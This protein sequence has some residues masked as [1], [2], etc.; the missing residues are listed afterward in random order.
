MRRSI[1]P[2]GPSREI[3]DRLSLFVQPVVQLADLLLRLYLRLVGARRHHHVSLTG[4]ARR[5]IGDVLPTAWISPLSIPNEEGA[6]EAL[7]AATSF[8]TDSIFLEA[9]ERP[10]V[11]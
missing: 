10:R 8:F 6:A 11:R 1:S 9:D 7:A 4:V 5:E 2:D 3:L